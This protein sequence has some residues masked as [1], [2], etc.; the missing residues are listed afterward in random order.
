VVRGLAAL[1]LAACLFALTGEL[2]VRALDPSP[3]VQIVRPREGTRGIAGFR[4][5]HGEPLWT[6]EGSGPRQ[7]PGC[8]PEARTVLLLGSSILWGTGYAPEQ[9]VSAHLQERLDPT[10]QRVC[11]RNHAQPAYVG[12]NKLA[13]AR[14]L[15][16]R[17]RP[18]VVVW[19]VWTSDPA[20]Y[21]VLDGVAYN[22]G[23][24]RV[25]EDGFPVLVP[26]VPS[27][28]HHAL[29]RRSA[30]WRYANLSQLRQDSEVYE[31]RWRAH[32]ATRMPEVARLTA[33]AGGALL[34]AFA[35]PLDR[36]FADFAA[37][38][39][40]KKRGYWWARGWADEAGVPWIDLAT[41]LSGQDVGALRHDPCC[42]FN[43]DG[44]AALAE[45]LAP[46]IEAALAA[47]TE[48]PTS[49]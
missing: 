5:V 42:H 10:R 14:E 35:P 31:A 25:D 29:F 19:E 32:L 13:E 41:E 43:P 39:I 28:L 7:D 3:G 34:L 30:L 11:V 49:P 47:A 27:V 44:H 45:A 6:H 16:P 26:G 23:Q 37:D 12:S 2:V 48:A 18:A 36:P 8:G 1:T 33:E 4:V 9:V 38:V 22:M 40:D 46:S 21:V 15:I 17:L 24:S 20:T